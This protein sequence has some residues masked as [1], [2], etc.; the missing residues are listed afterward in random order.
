MWL[1]MKSADR[2]CFLGIAKLGSRQRSAVPVVDV[3]NCEQLKSLPTFLC[4]DRIV[5]NL[6]SRH[7]DVAHSGTRP[8]TKPIR[9]DPS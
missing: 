3:K 6:E 1:R 4:N 2:G 5:H 7:T 9:G 8:C